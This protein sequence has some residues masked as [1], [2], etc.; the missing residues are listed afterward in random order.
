MDR[1][2]IVLGKPAPPK[3]FATEY[4]GTWDVSSKPTGKL[5]RCNIRRIKVPEYQEYQ[6]HTLQ[7]TSDLWGN[8]TFELQLYDGGQN[9]LYFLNER[10]K[11][12][13]GTGREIYM[14]VTNIDVEDSTED[15]YR[16]ITITGVEC[17]DSSVV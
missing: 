12:S 4:L 10:I 3:V 6:I 7:M 17:P 2:A 5:H 13:L 8:R 1:Y 11:F 14:V 16:K 9:G 15:P